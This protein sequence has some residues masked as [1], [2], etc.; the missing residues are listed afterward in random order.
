MPKGN[1]TPFRTASL[2]VRMQWRGK[3]HPPFAET[4]GDWRW[5]GAKGNAW[6]AP[7]HPPSRQVQLVVVDRI[8]LDMNP[9]LTTAL[10]MPYNLS[11]LSVPICEMGMVIPGPPP[12]AFIKIK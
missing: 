8:H 10:G 9:G 2:S 4:W 1:K 5:G 11:D 12:M 3:E 7:H 6:E